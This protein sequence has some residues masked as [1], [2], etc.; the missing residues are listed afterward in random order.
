MEDGVAFDDKCMEILR[1]AANV[2]KV[3]LLLHDSSPDGMLEAVVRSALEIAGVLG[4][5]RGRVP[6]HRFLVCSTP[7]GK[8]A[9]VRQLEAAQHIECDSGVHDELSRFGVPQ[10]LLSRPGQRSDLAAKVASLHAPC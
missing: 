8:V 7:V 9:I 2:S 6:K 3:F 10:W 5:G 4:D 1:E